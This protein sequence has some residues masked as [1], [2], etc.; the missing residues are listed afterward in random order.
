MIIQV[1]KCKS[2]GAEF[3]P[4]QISRASLSIYQ[5]PSSG[6]LP[7][8]I[9]RGPKTSIWTIKKQ[10]KLCCKRFCMCDCIIALIIST[11]LCPFSHIS[12]LVW[13]KMRPTNL[14]IG[15]LHIK[16][17]WT[18]KKWV[19]TAFCNAVGARI[20]SGFDLASAHN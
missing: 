11:S 13:P 20:F 14:F 15:S 16:M 5:L 8:T 6:F 17:H 4:A 19:K 9:G 3:F 1:S 10:Q 12:Q 7:S 2:P 18:M